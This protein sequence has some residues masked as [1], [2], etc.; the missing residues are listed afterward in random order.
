MMVSNLSLMGV[1]SVAYIIGSWFGPVSL[2]VPTIMVSKLLC[3]LVVRAP[4]GATELRSPQATKNEA[5]RFEP[6]RPSSAL[7]PARARRQIMGVILRMDTFSKEQQV[8]VYCITCAILTLPEIGP[9]DQDCIDVPK[10][11]QQ[12]FASAPAAA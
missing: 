4:R 7:S 1:A 5:P 12:P 11:L 8:G 6:G 9:R 2:A 3:N 10:L